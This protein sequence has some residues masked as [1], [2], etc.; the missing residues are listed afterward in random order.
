M[1][2]L[3]TLKSELPIT[4]LH[5]FKVPF[6][7]EISQTFKSCIAWSNQFSRVIL[8]TNILEDI[9]GHDFFGSL[10][11]CLPMALSLPPH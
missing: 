5:V 6:A 3:M 10:V 1:K 11:I 4:R 8:Q 7:F 9:G 2:K